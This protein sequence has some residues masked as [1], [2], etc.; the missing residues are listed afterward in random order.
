MRASE[1]SNPSTRAPRVGGVRR[2]LM[3]TLRAQG[4][5]LVELAIVLFVITI[6]MGGMLT[7]ITQQIAERQNSE[8]RH[9]MESGRIALTG[10]ALSHRDPDGHPYLPCPTRSDGEEERLADGRCAIQVG[11]LPWRTL[12]V[13]EVDA[14]G[15]HLD[16]AVT[17]DYADAHHGIVTSP[18]PAARVRICQASTCERPQAAVAALL[19][20]GRNGFGAHN[21][22]GRSNLAPISSDE[23]ANSDGTARFVLRPPSAADRAGGEFDDLVTWISPSWLLGRLCDPAETC[24]G[25]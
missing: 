9:A 16:Y 14:W 18:L 25:P 12:G 13:A 8:T 22:M 19:S 4:F 24:A 2:A 7:P 6:L 20:H 10:Y 23:R 17:P 15:N 5:T 21:A 3:Y 11:I 1:P